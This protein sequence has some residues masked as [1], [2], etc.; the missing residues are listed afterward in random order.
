MSFTITLSSCSDDPRKLTKTLSGQI[1]VS[2]V[3]PTGIVD[4]MNPSFE[5]DYDSAYTTKNYCE[6]GAPF[7]RS[8]F[9]TDMKIDIGKKIII[10]CAVDVLQTYNGQ[11]KPINAN[12]IRQEA[13]YATGDSNSYLPDPE[14]KIRSGYQNYSYVWPY[15]AFVQTPTYILNV[16][17][18]A[19]NKRYAKLEDPTTPPPDWSTSWADYYVEDGAGS[20][21]YI[22]VGVPF[23][24][25]IT[26][27]Y[28]VVY[29]TY[30]GVYKRLW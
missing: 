7:N 8:Y 28:D 21:T 10:S 14:Y 2:N 17:G 25:T 9:I 30:Q 4:L 3:R 6:V 5:L 24:F 15:H 12:I 11:I 18:G 23:G 13:A 22:S 20:D 29:T 19:N 16:I 27:P 26:P 1:S